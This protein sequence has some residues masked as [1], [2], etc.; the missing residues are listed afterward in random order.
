MQQKITIKGIIKSKFD[1]IPIIFAKVDHILGS[2]SVRRS[3]DKTIEAH[4]KIVTN[5]G[6]VKGTSRWKQMCSHAI[7][8]LEL[9]EPAEPSF[10]VGSRDNWPT[11]L[12][13]LRPFR[14]VFHNSDITKDIRSEVYRYIITV[15]KINSVCSE[16]NYLDV[17]DLP[18][19]FALN[20]DLEKEFISYLSLRLPK[21]DAISNLS[22]LLVEKPM[23]GPA[24]GPN[25]VPKLQ[26]ATAEALHLLS[27]ELAAPFK[28]YCELT[29]NGDY[30]DYIKEYSLKDNLKDSGRLKKDKI[31]LRKI[32]SIADKGNKSRAIAICDFWTQTLLKPLEDEELNQLVKNFA[33]KSSFFSHSDGF[34]KILSEYNHEWLSID[35]SQWTDNFP[36]RLQYLYLKH[37]Y[38]KQLA[39][40]WR[41]LVVDC[42]WTIG[43]STD[44]VTYGRGQ[45]MGTKGSFMIA[46]VTDHFFI[47]FI[48]Q[49][50]YGKVNNYN[51]VGDDLVIQDEREIFPTEYPKIGVGINASKT[52]RSTPIGKFV[53][54][55]SRIG[56]DSIDVSHVSPNLIQR[57]HR[58]P[59]LFPV[60]IKHIMERMVTFTA[61]DAL[62][63]VKNMGLSQ[64]EVER[65]IKVTLLHQSFT[66]DILLDVPTENTNVSLSNLTVLNCL[67]RLVDAYEESIELIL[68]EQNK[69]VGIETREYG[70][71]LANEFWMSGEGL[72]GFARKQ[73]LQLADIQL[74]TMSARKIEDERAMSATFGDGNTRFPGLELSYDLKMK[75]HILSNMIV[76]LLIVADSKR[77]EIK[78]IDD[79][80]PKS[81]KNVKTYVHYLK[82]LNKILKEEE[83]N[84][85]CGDGDYSLEYIGRSLIKSKM[86]ASI[87]NFLY[88]K[89]SR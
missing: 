12:G 79:Y 20:K 80:N 59:L 75:N 53:E 35:A 70:E 28:E 42:A 63:L 84:P 19:K 74:L 13:H 55:V 36:S 87:P 66:G 41:K 4:N 43:N 30:L 78:L 9:R 76:D 68:V 48:S 18:R 69:Y 71:A 47:E 82:A 3:L 40:A 73:N 31:L 45:G 27:S 62:N 54:Y 83:L 60:L 23:M 37:R 2:D 1:L 88:V 52:K 56:W 51:K 24:N 6:V 58:Q 77:L 5:Y 46:S 10:S 11:V 29:G 32:T 14:D 81:L 38:G 39:Y 67:F 16:N 57:V 17:S 22:K 49:K 33:T 85:L 34:T 15:L 72:F 61:S 8:S 64:I 25:S 89:P 44:T 86:N 21:E 7:C 50:F 26:S 65:I